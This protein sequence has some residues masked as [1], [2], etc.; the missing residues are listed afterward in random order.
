MFS[1]KEGINKSQR[2]KPR[3]RE[4]YDAIRSHQD[5]MFVRGEDKSIVSPKSKPIQN[6]RAR[7]VV[8][9]KKGNKTNSN[10]KRILIHFIR[11]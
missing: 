7:Q 9:P 4:S 11:A 5:K 8:N 10:E 6:I 1:N 3:A 2:F